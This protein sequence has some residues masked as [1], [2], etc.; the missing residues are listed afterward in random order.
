M[1]YRSVKNSLHE[2]EESKYRVTMEVQVIQT[3]L[4]HIKQRLE[5]I[6]QKLDRILDK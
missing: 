1:D 4:S 6:E 5:R 3:E 2:L